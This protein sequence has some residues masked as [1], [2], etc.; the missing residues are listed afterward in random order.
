MSEAGTII[1]PFRQR[2]ELAA[3]A[4]W[5]RAGRAAYQ[6][7]PSWETFTFGQ[8][9]DTF[10]RQIRPSCEIWV[11]VS[12]DRLVAFIAMAGSYID[13]MY[14]DPAEWRRGW[15]S[16]LLIHAKALRPSGLELHTHQENHPARQLY[17]KHGFEAVKFGTSPAPESVPDV[18]YHWRPAVVPE[19]HT[20]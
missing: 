9:T 7:L 1:R 15:G 2:D 10:R 17:E 20:S 16:R 19:N 5:H 14:V 6:Y 13:R 18:E 12:D 4:V 3:I 11:G 8:A